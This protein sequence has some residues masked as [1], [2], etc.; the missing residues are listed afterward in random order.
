M[1][2]SLPG[3]SRARQIQH[4]LAVPYD[5]DEVKWLPK[6]VRNGKALAFAYVDARVVMDRLDSVLGVT[7]WQDDYRFLPDGAV[8]C[9]LRCKIDGE[10]ITRT[11]VGGM[12]EQPDE[13]DRR[14]AAVSDA[15]K[16]ASV[17]FG[18]GRYLY[19]LPSAWAEY[20]EKAKRFTEVPSLPEWAMPVTYDQIK[21]L[22]VLYKATGYTLT[23]MDREWGVT[24]SKHLT[25]LQASELIRDLETRRKTEAQ[26]ANNGAVKEG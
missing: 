10:W 15:L 19:S 2:E 5:P 1:S 13:G 17:K 18:V 3:I 4:A 26:T 8:V 25:R 16:R 23:D 12:S 6:V 11:D 21:M 7:G 20:D 14:K 9:T 24:S 22:H